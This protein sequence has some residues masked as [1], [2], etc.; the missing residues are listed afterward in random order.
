MKEYGKLVR[1]RIPGIIRS[2]G[3]KCE[4]HVAGDE[5]YRSL[6]ALKLVE[7]AKEFAEEPGVDELADVLEVIEA[8]HAVY[9][10]DP[11]KTGAARLE[12]RGKRGGFEERIVLDRA[13]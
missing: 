12:K 3:E 1:D 4:T 8:I 13:D 6:L 10:I 7:E 11:D 2:K 9:G 5:E